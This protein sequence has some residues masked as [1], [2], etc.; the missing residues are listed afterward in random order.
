MKQISDRSPAAGI[1]LLTVICC[2]L[3][4]TLIAGLTSPQI[5]AHAGLSY[6]ADT[7]QQAR[8]WQRQYLRVALMLNNFFSYTA[9]ALVA[10]LLCFRRRALTVLQYHQ[11]GFRGAS[12]LALLLFLAAIPL[13]IYATWLNLQVPLPEWAVQ[14]EAY[15]NRIIGTVLRMESPAEFLLAFTAMAITPAIGEEL[16][17]RGVIQKNILG[18][19]SGNHHFSIW[20][21]AAIFSAAHFELA[22]FLPRLLLGAVLGYSYYWTRSIWTPILLHLLFNGGQVI[23]TYLSGEYTADTEM[24]VVPGWWVGAVGLASTS[25]IWW[26]AE[27]RKQKA[28]ADAGAK[29]G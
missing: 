7:L 26:Y 18:G 22:G 9:T 8:E 28:G 23:S 15:I 19:L 11:P 16:L 2:Y 24:E 4:F 12:A 10:L 5:N 21:A 14:D 13:V 25:L 29:E 20:L 17:Y 1:L 27:G 6:D 3:F